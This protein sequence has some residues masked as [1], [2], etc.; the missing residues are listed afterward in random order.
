MS[1]LALPQPGSRLRGGGEERRE[2]GRCR[3]MELFLCHNLCDSGSGVL[4]TE[5]S[6]SL[7]G[8]VEREPASLTEAGAEAG[9][10]T[11]SLARAPGRAG[12]AVLSL[13]PPDVKLREAGH[14]PCWKSTNTAS[15]GFC[16]L[17]SWFPG[18]PLQRRVGNSRR[19]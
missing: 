8:P 19:F 1:F 12:P 17:E 16:F 11:P 7:S 14:Q 10:E 6:E 9:P 3:G 2:R 15:Q 13:C 5:G 4:R 18:T